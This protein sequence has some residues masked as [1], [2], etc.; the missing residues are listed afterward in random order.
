[1]ATVVSYDKLRPSRLGC[2]PPRC[3]SS[4]R[5][6]GC[7][8][9]AWFAA[10]GLSKPIWISLSWRLISAGLGWTDLERLGLATFGPVRDP[11]LD[12]QPRAGLAGVGPPRPPAVPGLPG[13]L[14]SVAAPRCARLARTVGV[15]GRTP[16]CRACPDRW[17]WWPRPLCR[18][19][20]RPL[21]LVA[22]PA[23][24]GLAQAVGVGG[25]AR[26]ARLA[27]IAGVGGRA[28]CAGSVQADG[29]GGPLVAPGLL[30]SPLGSL[31]GWRGGCVASWVGWVGRSTGAGCR[32]LG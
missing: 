5:R 20:P 15:G 23:V 2:P 3:S 17:G 19:L 1:M 24:P 29:G 14:E 30:S 10:S 32:L 11:E 6:G 13:P 18:G 26:C 7:T 4:T 12:W 16:L 31:A 28:R 21:G 27:Q 22:A 9:S 25:P 8:N